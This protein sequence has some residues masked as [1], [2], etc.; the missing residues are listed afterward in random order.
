VKGEGWEKGFHKGIL[1][2]IF[3]RGI[4]YFKISETRAIY[5]I[6]RKI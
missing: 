6:A 1:L 5:K 4:M 3:K 2:K